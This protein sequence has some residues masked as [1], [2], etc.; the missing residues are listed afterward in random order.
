MTHTTWNPML[1][2]GVT[3]DD[4]RGH[5]AALD[6]AD[7]EIL[8]VVADVFGFVWQM[9]TAWWTYSDH[10][11]EYG[12]RRFRCVVFGFT[13]DRW[14]PDEPYHEG[15]EWRSSPGVT[16]PTAALREALR[17]A[18]EHVAQQFEDVEDDDDDD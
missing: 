7:F 17:L 2:P 9:G 14:S 4:I 15:D 5:L 18:L 3:A 1:P 13:R 12:S 11:P 6:T 16:D 10:G 8:T